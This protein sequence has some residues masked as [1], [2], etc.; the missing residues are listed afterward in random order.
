M[1][2]FV[3]QN[4]LDAKQVLIFLTDG[5]SSGGV[6]Q[7]VQQLKNLGVIIFSIG[8]G[9]GV[10]QSELET[11]ASSPA[12]KH[13]HLLGSF[14]ELSILAGTMSSTT[15]S[16]MVIIRFIYHCTLYEHDVITGA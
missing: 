7:P 5:Q 2:F 3:W 11:I 6:E 13:V 10:S 15:C 16:G 12:D 8:V 1:L 14:N 4:I 9:S